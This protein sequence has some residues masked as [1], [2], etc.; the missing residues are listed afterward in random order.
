MK[1]FK[2]LLAISALFSLLVFMGCGPDDDPEVPAGK[3]TS[4][5]LTDGTWIPSGVSNANQPRDEWA[6]FTVSFSS[7][8]DF[9]GGTY[10]TTGLP[11]EDTDQIVWKPSGTWEFGEEGTKF[12]VMIRDGDT[13]VPVSL[14]VDTNEDGSEGTLNM[15][16]EL[17]DPNARA[18]GF[19]GKWVFAMTF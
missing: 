11:S 16:F 17:V 1:Y 8:T 18:E 12:N 10:A 4:D 7:N 2:K 14:V 6:D 9:T 5:Q 15:Q 19:F 3:A 13:D